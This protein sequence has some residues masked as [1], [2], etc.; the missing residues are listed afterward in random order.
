MATMFFV[1]I[2]NLV[3]TTT[4]TTKTLPTP[5]IK[6]S[7]TRTDP[8]NTLPCRF[9]SSLYY[10]QSNSTSVRLQFWSNWPRLSNLRIPPHN[11]IIWRRQLCPTPAAAAITV[12]HSAFRSTS[13][14]HYKVCVC[15]NKKLHTY[16][17]IWQL[18]PSFALYKHQCSSNLTQTG[19][20]HL[21]NTLLGQ[22]LTN[23]SFIRLASVC[24]S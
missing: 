18:L 3:N 10:L 13:N 5:P 15:G 20:R 8:S 24:C 4:T 1:S 23:K 21:H 7:Y 19:R 6:S 12:L 17:S 11:L 22:L 16:F 14:Q 9:P 2:A